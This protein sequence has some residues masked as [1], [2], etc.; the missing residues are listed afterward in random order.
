VARD[1]LSVK[2]DRLYYSIKPSSQP[3][4]FTGYDYMLFRVE[5]RNQRDDWRLKN[6]QEPLDKA[7]EATL[8]GESEKAG[9]YRT[10][11]LTAALQSPDLAVYDRRRVAQAIKEELVAIGSEG[12][13][14]V[15]DEIR[16]LNSI[17]EAR[18]ISMD[19]AAARGEMSF[20]ELFAD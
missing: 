3:V 16:D 13:G 15:G 9:A 8:Q 18:A 12:L 17:V 4:P 6:I 11:A 5:G 19:Q 1:R 10:V 20:E 2:E 14:A 7:I